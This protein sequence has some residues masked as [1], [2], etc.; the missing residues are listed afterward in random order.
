MVYQKDVLIWIVFQN[1]DGLS[2]VVKEAL[3][4]AEDEFAVI[5][6]IIPDNVN[7][8][9]LELLVVKIEAISNVTL[10]LTGPDFTA[11][12]VEDPFKALGPI[13][14]FSARKYWTA[15]R[16]IRLQKGT[17]SI[18]QKRKP[19]TCHCKPGT[20]IACDYC[21]SRS[22][23]GSVRSGSTNSSGKERVIDSFGF[24]VRGDAPVVISNVETNS[25]AEVSLLL[26]ESFLN[27]LNTLFPQTQ[28]LAV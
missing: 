7:D 10:S 23:N 18:V 22:N 11:H 2:K 12:K 21:K 15:P 6:R 13:G 28:S 3:S 25:L 19:K 5:D 20:L 26:I 9:D 1:K 14:V 8:D 17:G 27:H 24:N 16:S 4:A